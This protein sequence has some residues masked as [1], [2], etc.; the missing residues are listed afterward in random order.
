MVRTITT[1]VVAE[2]DLTMAAEED[3]EGLL[4]RADGEDILPEGTIPMDEILLVGDITIKGDRLRLATGRLLRT[5]AAITEEEDLRFTTKI[6]TEEHRGAIIIIT[7]TTT[8]LAAGVDRAPCLAAIRREGVGAAVWP[9]RAPEA[10]VVPDHPTAAAS[11][12]A[13]KIGAEEE[14]DAG[15]ITTVNPR[16][17][18]D[19]RRP[20]RDLPSRRHRPRHRPL[21]TTKAMWKARNSSPR[22]TQAPPPK[23]ILPKIRGRYLSISWSCARPP[24]TF[25]ITF[26]KKWEPRSMRSFCSRIAE[27]ANTRDA[28]MSK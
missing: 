12:A 4:L 19:D 15:S 9:R 6:S 25:V 5:I 28:P 16:V 22:R 13:A 11:G 17:A 8:G 1:I 7:T 18:A 21:L 3:D 10:T 23:T 24:R 26:G 27:P 14:E 2:R 20:R